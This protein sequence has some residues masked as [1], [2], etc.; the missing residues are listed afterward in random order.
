M[1]R[2]NQNLQQQQQQ[3]LL[4]ASMRYWPIDTTFFRLV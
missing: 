3:L 4:I 2:Q 1:H